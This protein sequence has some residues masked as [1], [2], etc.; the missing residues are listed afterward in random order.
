MAAG[1][2]CARFQIFRN[3]KLLFVTQVMDKNDSVLGA[4]HGWVAELAKHVEKVIVICLYE[5]EHDLPDN[6][7][8][9]SL[10]KEKGRANPLVYAI[11]FKALAWR[12]RHEYDA[13]LV[14]MNQEYLLIAGLLWK[15]LGKRM[16][17]WRNHY[18]GSWLTDV[19]ASFCTKVFCTSH[20]SYT[21]KYKKTVFMPVGVNLERFHPDTQIK[22]E[23][24][25]ILFLARI[26]PSKRPDLFIEALGLLI[27]KG[28]SFKASVYGSPIPEDVSYYESLKGRAED[29]GLHARV[30]FH[31]GVPNS[32]TPN[33]YRAHEV[34]VNCSPSG[35]FDKT[36][37]EAAASGCLVLAISEDFGRVAGEENTFTAEAESLAESL[38]TLLA[39]SAE[40]R[41]ILSEKL[42]AIA[43]KNALTVLAD[44]LTRELC[45]DANL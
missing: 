2:S 24:N 21:A 26:S 37:F 9:Y 30:E 19:A 18:A 27:A 28:I 3:M 17:M 40:E 8:V 6:V 16:Y 38:K 43:G 33:I 36:I 15:L 25:S 1:Q 35:M 34:F 39:E 23:P 44:T 42:E 13:V 31:A 14:H 12:L 22:R 10:G 5:G 4:Y 45:Y 32:E 7:E 41:A 11:R 20:H 29:L